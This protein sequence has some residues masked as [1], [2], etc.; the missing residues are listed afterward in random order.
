MKTFAHFWQYL[1]EFFLEWETKFVEKIKIHIS[2]S[3]T[4]FRKSSRLWDNVE[5][6]GATNDA[7]NDNIAHARCAPDKTTRARHMHTPTRLGTH[8][9]ARIHTEKGLILLFHNYNGF[10][11]APDCYVIRTL[12]VLLNYNTLRKTD[13]YNKISL[14]SEIHKYISLLNLVRVKV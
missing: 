3:I 13:I 1:A 4:F 11:N 14:I 12:P 7:K 2:C 5:K 10:G 9:S 6:Y 8:T